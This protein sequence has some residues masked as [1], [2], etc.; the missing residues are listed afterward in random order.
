MA[1][2]YDRD[3]N[4][5]GFNPTRVGPQP[6]YRGAHLQGIAA[7]GWFRTTN[8]SFRPR[9]RVTLAKNFHGPRRDF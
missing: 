7:Y 9:Q 2:K 3:H 4:E 1:S 5:F 6:N 8:N